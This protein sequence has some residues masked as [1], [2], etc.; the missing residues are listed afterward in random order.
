MFNDFFL[1]AN[2]VHYTVARY[3]RFVKRADVALVA[4]QVCLPYRSW[5]GGREFQADGVFL[6][7]AYRHY[8]S[9]VQPGNHR[10]SDAGPGHAPL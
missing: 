6:S 10:A 9:I 1:V 3:C 8:V 4:C 5:A 2:G 7:V